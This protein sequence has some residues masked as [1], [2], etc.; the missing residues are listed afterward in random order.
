MRCARCLSISASWPKIPGCLGRD[1][2]RGGRG[3]DAAIA[4]RELV[5]WLEAPE[6][7]MAMPWP[8]PWQGRRDP[9]DQ[10]SH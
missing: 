5:G 9:P 2:R 8:W 1:S 10:A 4:G 3:I 7:H 6:A